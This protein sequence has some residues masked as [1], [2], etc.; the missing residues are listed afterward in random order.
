MDYDY[1]CDGIF[2]DYDSNSQMNNVS[3]EIFNRD[4]PNEFRQCTKCNNFNIKSTEPKFKNMCLECFKNSR[5][6]EKNV[7]S[8]F[9]NCEQCGLSNI[10]SK[11]PLYVKKCNTCLNPKTGVSNFRTCERCLGNNIKLTDPSWKVI[12]TECFNQEKSNYLLCPGCNLP[13]IKPSSSWQKIC[14]SCYKSNQQ[15]VIQMSDIVQYK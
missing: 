1:D 7:F 11:K 13:K 12:C 2:D 10:D 8:T 3:R 6:E 4:A 5:K 15:N 9:R 14:Y